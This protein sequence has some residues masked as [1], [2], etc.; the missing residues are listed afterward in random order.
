[1]ASRTEIERSIALANAVIE[2]ATIRD[3][4]VTTSLAGVLMA[5]AKMGLLL[6]MPR[7]LILE[8]MNL[9][10]DAAEAGIKRD[11]KNAH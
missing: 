7:S 10:L 3:P 8:G 2:F 1:M 4:D 5:G 11:I 6:T 9:A